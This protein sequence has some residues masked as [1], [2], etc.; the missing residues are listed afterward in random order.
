MASCHS[1]F[2]QEI[3]SRSQWFVARYITLS[4]GQSKVAR[5][6]FI[7]FN[8]WHPASDILSNK[9][10]PVQIYFDSTTRKDRKYEHILQSK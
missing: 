7:H 8:D 9:S 2:I 1:C 5:S 3:D 6:W 4:V 10:V